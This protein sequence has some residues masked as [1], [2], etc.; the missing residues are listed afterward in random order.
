MNHNQESNIAEAKIINS[1]KLENM[2]RRNVI[3]FTNQEQQQLIQLHDSRHDNVKTTRARSPEKRHSAVSFY[4][5]D[6][7]VISHTTSKLCNRKS[8]FCSEDEASDTTLT[9]TLKQQNYLKLSHFKTLPSWYQDNEFI[10]FFYRP[11][12]ESYR[13]CLASIFR[14]HN[15]TFNIW[16]HLVPLIPIVYLLY[17][18]ILRTPKDF[19]L[20]LEHFRLEA[21]RSPENYS[22]N[23]LYEYESTI[24]FRQNLHIF[25]YT[26]IFLLF[27]FSTT[28]HTLRAGFEA[29]F[30]V[31]A[32]FLTN[33]WISNWF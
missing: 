32:F 9:A 7:S 15:E 17:D 5:S 21:Q 29:T 23:D 30:P 2:S 10:L 24:S 18:S 19:S 1:I 13:K 6:K 12:S 28:F 27:L 20:N 26:S 25:F 16:S 33:F 11:I 3:K 8:S 14:L 4:D 31:Q 22:E